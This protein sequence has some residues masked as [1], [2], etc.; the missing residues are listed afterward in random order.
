MQYVLHFLRFLLV[1]WEVCERTYLGSAY[2]HD[3]TQMR[4][5]QWSPS[6][7]IHCSETLQHV[8]GAARWCS[9]RNRT[10]MATLIK[11]YIHI[12]SHNGFSWNM[13][14]D[15]TYIQMSCHG[16]RFLLSRSVKL[17]DFNLL[18]NSTHCMQF[19]R[20]CLST[21][22]SNSHCHIS[23]HVCFILCHCVLR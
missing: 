17:L 2:E 23:C 3:C 6:F 7:N 5:I 22:D 12:N 20:T 19:M 15:S 18:L 21:P 13:I 11:L 10:L 1:R 8:I 14:P 4:L 9:S 16:V